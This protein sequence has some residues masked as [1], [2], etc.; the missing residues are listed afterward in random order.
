MQDKVA[1]VGPCNLIIGDIP[2]PLWLPFG[3]FPLKLGARSG[4]IFPQNYEFSEAWGFGLREMGW[5]FPLSERMD[6]KLTGDIYFKGTFRIHG[7]SNYRK[8]YKNNGNIDLV[9]ARLRNEV[10]GVAQFDPTASIQW[11]HTQDSKAHPYRS[12]GGNI[13][14]QIGNHAKSNYT[15]A[16]S[17]LSS[18]L[19]SSM[20]YQ[21]RFDGPYNLSV[22]FN[23]SQNTITRDVT[24]SF[25]TLSFQTQSLYPFKRKVQTGKERFYEKIT[26]KYSSEARNQF[27]AKD[28]T[29]FSR[30]TLDDAKYGVRH[31]VTT[32]TS[33]NLLKYF[34][35]SPSA[36]YKEV[37]FFKSVKKEFDSTLIIDSIAVTSPTGEVSYLP[38]TIQAGKIDTIENFGLKP[39]RSYSMGVSMSTKIFGTILFKKGKIRGLRH[40]ITPTFGFNFSPDYSNPDWG[41]FKQVRKDLRSDELLTYNIFENNQRSGFEIP[42]LTTGR[43]MAISYGFSNLFEAKIFSK[44]DSTEKKLSLLRSLSV[45]GSYNFAADSLRFSPLSLSGNTGFF[46]NITTVRFGASFS[47]YAR[48]EKT[49]APVNQFYWE[50][51]KKPLRLVSWDFGVNTGMTVSRIRDLI[52]GEDSDKRVAQTSVGERPAFDPNRPAADPTRPG[53][54]QQPE[55]IKEQDFLD[56]FEDFSINHTFNMRHAFTRGKDSTYV[57]LN[58]VNVVGDIQITPNWHINIGNIGYDFQ[59][60]KLTYP[61]LGFTRDLHCWEMGLFWQPDYGTY[62]FFIRVKPGKLDFLNIPY[63]KGQQDGFRRR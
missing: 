39:Y 48:N 4:L 23:H 10:E 59:A 46:N 27:T 21:Q 6:L 14:L 36:T 32:S 8:R 47:P 54:E 34:T 57:S 20:S 37:W 52:K 5:Y 49:G 12:L 16:R 17:V 60:K 15:D 19:S 41:Y 7:V 45:N 56:L 51:Q 50:T 33:F 40:I 53:S 42:S 31:N 55:E 2:T 58:S 30:K 25:P 13:N 9:F 18:T 29:L 61:D 11:R 63:R 3:F 28:T 44:K 26:L 62:S 1:I 24:I 38:D 22:A 35:V 43:Q